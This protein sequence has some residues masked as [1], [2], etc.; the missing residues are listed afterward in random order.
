MFSAA[1]AKFL[2]LPIFNMLL[3]KMFK[4]SLMADLK[5]EGAAFA[6]LAASSILFNTL[7]SS[8]LFVPNFANPCATS[9]PKFATL[10]SIDVFEA[11]LAAVRAA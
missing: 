4:F 1:C 9:L 8:T 10:P 6:I 5:A 7:S 11:A 2:D 3:V